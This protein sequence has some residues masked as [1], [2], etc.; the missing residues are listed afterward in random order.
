MKCFSARED[1]YFATEFHPYKDEINSRIL[2]ECKLMNFITDHWNADGS[3]TNIMALQTLPVHCDKDFYNQ[4]ASMGLLVD[5][6]IDITRKVTKKEAYQDIG[7]MYVEHIWVAKYNKGD[8]TKS[9]H[10]HPAIYSF[11]YF[12]K[13][14]KGSSSLVF[15]T[16]GKR[17]KAEDGK[18][19]LF[20]GDLRHHVPKNRSDGRVVLAGNIFLQLRGTFL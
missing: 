11:V 13:S 12:V 9:H 7:K 15:T 17:I 1:L 2:E 18:L 19:V 8:W 4:F 16:S 20:P 5:W 14:P 10:H 3:F 6:V